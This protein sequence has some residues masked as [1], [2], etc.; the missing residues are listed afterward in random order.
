MQWE[1]SPMYHNEVLMC[2]MEAVRI[3]RIYQDSLFTSKELDMIRKMALVD[4]CLKNPDNRQPMVGD[5]DDTDLRDLITQAAYLFR[6]GILKFGGFERLDYESIWLF[7]VDAAEAYESMKTV[8]VPGALTNLFSSGQIVLREGWDKDSFWMYYV[9]GPQGG[10]HGHSDKLHVS[11]WMDG[12]EIL[13]DPGRYTYT[14]TEPRYQLKNAVSHNVPMVNRKEYAPAVESWSCAALPISTPNYVN[15]RD[16]FVLIEGAHTGY[17]SLGIT[18]N[19]RILV[20]G[21]DAIV[22]C[23]DFIGI[24]PKTVTQ[25]FHFGEDMELQQMDNRV[26]GK[27]EFAQFCMYSY[28]GGK[29]KAVQLENGLFSRHYNQLSQCPVSDLTAEGVTTLTT[30]LVRTTK[31]QAQ[32]ESVPVENYSYPHVLSENEAEG[33]MITAGD[34]RYGVVLLHQDVG[35]NADLNGFEGVYGLGRTMACDLQK[36]PKYMTVLQW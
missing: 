6:D 14:D 18:V 27:G 31:Q 19:R 29:P 12:D 21:Y 36:A 32:V 15:R 17:A 24:K 8:S 13:T 4:M 10:G 33:Y 2:M 25:R 30:I 35:N 3:S 11:L 20:L 26:F 28:A 5:S 22:I 16:D 7:G 1:T 9:N 23:D 34:H